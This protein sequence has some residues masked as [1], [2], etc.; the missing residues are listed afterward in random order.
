MLLVA[1][2][3]V[4]GSTVLHAD[5]L[6]SGHDHYFNH[7]IDLAIDSYSRYIEEKPDDP[8][9]Y[10]YLALSLLYAEV[11]RLG[12]LETS[13]FRGDEEFYDWEKPEPNPDVRQ[14][15]FDAARKSMQLCEQQLVKDESDAQA[16][17]TLSVTYAMRSNYQF[18]IGKS[19]VK[20]LNNARRAKNLGSKLVAAH[21]DFVDGMLVLGVYD[22][23]A[24]SLPWAAKIVAKIAGVSGKKKRGMALIARVA[25]DG[26]VN[27]NHA[28]LFL[29][30]AHRLEKQHLKSAAMFGELL[31]EFPRNYLYQLEMASMYRETGNDQ[32]AIEPLKNAYNKY[33]SGKNGFDRMPDRVVEALQRGIQKLEDA[34]DD[35][36]ENSIESS[37]AGP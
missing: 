21:P 27:N 35:I 16:L 31:K 17:M 11:V 20:A 6:A 12:K 22:Y 3:L 36:Q 30:L 19:Y 10:N 13:A 37:N 32:K 2:T 26:D 14:R 4:L 34:L 1:L 24:G 23:I 8:R 9:G 33:K 5:D 29:A 18:M 25:L 28:R 7:E 15:I